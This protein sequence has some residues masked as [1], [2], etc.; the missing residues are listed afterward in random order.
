MACSR[1]YRRTYRQFLDGDYTA[2]GRSG[3]V[4]HVAYASDPA[5]YVRAFELLLRDLR[6]LFDYVEPAESNVGC[7]SHRIQ[8]LLYRACVEVEANCGAIFADNHYSERPDVLN[9]GHFRK[10]ERTHLLSAYEVILPHWLGA[11]RIRRPF[12]AWAG[13]EG[14][15]W[16]RAYNQSKHA[17]HEA[18]AE[19]TFAHAIDACS[20][21]LVILSAQF[22]GHDFSSGDTLIAVEGPAD[23]TETGIGGYMRVRFPSACPTELRYDFDWETLKPEADPFL[24]FDYGTP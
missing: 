16:W 2:G 19:A 9:M 1:P 5:H 10:I 12:A 24:R 6:E 8:T 11:G 7:F 15:P 18:F 4:E 21:V 23:G 17:R 22:G 13:S 3:Y 14:V 20:A